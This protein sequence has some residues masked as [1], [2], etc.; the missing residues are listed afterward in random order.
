METLFCIVNFIF[1]NSAVESSLVRIRWL[2]WRRPPTRS[3]W[4]NLTSVHGTRVSF[5]VEAH[6]LIILWNFVP[7]QIN[8][9]E[10]GVVSNGCLPPGFSIFL[11][12]VFVTSDPYREEFHPAHC[13]GIDGRGGSD[14]VSKQ[15]AWRDWRQEWRW[16]RG[17]RW[18]LCRITTT[19]HKSSPAPA[20][21]VTRQLS[22]TIN[23]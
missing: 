7:V 21:N 14:P 11:V 18:R 9:F 22:V 20:D 13:I 8:T 5:W 12:F 19:S 15:T 17:P 4:M 2:E 16:W 6:Y 1:H 3:S 23:L 10:A